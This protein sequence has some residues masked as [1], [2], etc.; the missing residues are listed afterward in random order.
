MTPILNRAR[1]LAVPLAVAAVLAGSTALLAPAL[2]DAQS[3]HNHRAPAATAKK[4]TASEFALRNEMRRL[5]EDHIVWTRQVIVSFVAGTPDLDAALSRLLRNQ[6]DIGDAI[7][8]FYGDAAGESLS[9]LLR[10]HIVIAADVLAAAKAND[11]A[12][13]EDAQDRWAANADE[14][15]AFLS[16][17]NPEQW[18]L[19]EMQA[20][21]HEHL[22]LTTAEAVARLAADWKGDVD[23]YD[24]VHEQ[25]LHMADMLS[26][27]IV[28]QFPEQFRH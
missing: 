6:D 13:L 19:E 3:G 7:K 10:E 15:A 21:M 23:A 4:I 17:A 14:I 27:G 18:P 12:A 9:A 11:A 16:S 26:S 28:A 24:R 20:M 5:W 1:T 25:I 22:A 2:S 8:P